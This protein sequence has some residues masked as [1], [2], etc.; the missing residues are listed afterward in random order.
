MAGE[1]TVATLVADVVK[2]SRKSKSGTLPVFGKLLFQGAV[3][4][5]LA[6]Y[7]AARLASLAA[8]SLDFLEF[9]KAGRPKVRITNPETLPDV[10]VIEIANDDMPFLVNSV[11]GALAEAGHEIQLMLHPVLNVARDTSGKL[12]TLEEKFSPTSAL[13]RESFMHIHVTRIDATAHGRLSEALERI[14]SD[15]RIAVLDW[16]AMQARLKE[17]LADYRTNPPPIPVDNLTE[18][19]AFLQWLLDNHFTFLGM[20][21]YAFEGGPE[22]GQL[23]AVPRSG[24]GILRNEATQVLRRGGELVS[25]TPAIRNF[26]LEPS[27]LIV[28]KSDVRATVHRRAAMEYIG[29]KLFDGDGE[30]KGELRMVGLYTSSAYTQNPSEIPLLRRKIAAV[31]V[32]SGFNPTG[33]SGKA[34]ISVLETLPRDELFQVDPETL[35]AMAHGILRLEE[36]PR[37]RLFVRRDRFD[38]FVSAFAYIP[39]DRFNSEVRQR[40]GEIVAK[41]FDGRVAS[42]EPYFGEGVL[43][44]VHF[45][46]LRNPGSDPNPDLQALESDVV[47]AVRTW[48]DRL[49]AEL[50][51]A[52]V[53]FAA[54]APR[55]RGAFPAGYRDNVTPAQSLKDIA[56]LAALAGDGSIAAEFLA[57]RTDK[58][59]ECHLRLYRYGEAIPLSNRLPILENMGLKAIEETTFDVLPQGATA[60][61]HDVLLKSADGKP[62]DIGSSAPALKA[63]FMAVWSGAAEN[64]Y[65]NALSLTTRMGWRDIALLRAEARYLRQITATFTVEYMAATL[66]KH[67]DIATRLVAA[68]HARFD[69]KR[70]DAVRYEALR[71]E[72]DEALAKVPSLDEDRIIRR[73]LNLVG[74]MQRTNYFQTGGDGVHPATTAFKVDATRIEGLPEPHPFAEIFVYSPDVEGV[75]LRF[76]RIARGGIRWS[77]RPEDFRTEVLGLAKAQNVKNAVIVPVGAKGGFVPKKLPQGGTREAVQAEAVRAY[78]LFI[79][80]LLDITDNL[81]DGKIM[82]PADVARHDGDDPYL[83]VAA[84]KG[85]ASFSDIAN[86]ISA[87]H[88]FW[89]DDAFASG[90]SAGYD[91]KKMAITARGAWEAVKRHF[92]EMDIDIQSTPFT[93]IGIGDMSGDVFGNGMLLSRHIRLRAAFDHRDIFIDPDPDPQSSY[94]ERDRLFQ[95]PRSSWQ[96]YDRAKISKGGGIFSRQAKSIP[97]T[98]ELTQLTGLKGESATP[99]QVVHALLIVEMDLLWFGGIG[100]FVKATSESHADVGDR[101]NDAVR[102]DATELRAKVVGEGANLALTQRARIEYALAGGRLNTDAID[103]SA[104][105]NSSDLEV[106]IKIALRSAEASGKL[107][108]AKRN[109][110]LTE[111]TD[112]VAGLVLRNNYLQTLS[113]TLSRGRGTEENG[114]VIQLMHDLEER[115]MLDR[116]LESLPGDAEVLARDARH[117]TLTRPELAV[118]LAHS[119]IAL[120][121]DLLKSSVPDD[122]YLGQELKRYFPGRMFGEF[123]PEIESHRLK[124]EIVATLL[125][126]S[127]I[128]RGGP[129]FVSRLSREA[130]A[131]PADIAAAFAVARDSFDFIALNQQVDG[132]DGRITS[133]LQTEIYLKLQLRLRRA[134][135]WFLRHA[136]LANGLDRVIAHFRAGIAALDKV[137][138]ETLPE[139]AAARVANTQGQLTDAGVSEELA[140]RLSRL[141]YLQRAP[142]IV[143]LAG[144]GS[145]DMRATARALYGAGVHLGID[146]ILAQ[147][148]TLIAGDFFERLAINRTI[149]QVLLSHRALVQRV[150]AQQG[151]SGDPWEAWSGS[152]A[153]KVAQAQ[154]TIG[155][156]FA[157]KTFDLAKLAVAQGVLSDLVLVRNP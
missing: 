123:K 86:G 48:D 47:E 129:A 96:D 3:E 153:A 37:T 54:L 114:F 106:N 34:L 75:H 127:M 121:D 63:T 120:Y 100:T 41:A 4:D 105:V 13:T 5:D 27:A 102:I 62:I 18:S 118:L 38:R 1:D 8:S 140:A 81:V 30:L 109:E 82:P 68:F 39:R 46:I 15:V 33:H 56:V 80:S 112:E 58:T 92:R 14:L 40:I 45:I 141:R 20:R 55:W 126:N 60:V 145:A 156:L 65:F 130:G 26:L 52:G 9:R 70:G 143:Q 6:R 125:S 137:L 21:E 12:V 85:T 2:A 147:A 79:S 64:D 108:R 93:V 139:P 87:G 24:L 69:P 94:A 49:Q 28:T 135:L 99:Q 132:L 111:M 97:L 78:T 133:A 136:D 103:N 144:D 66:V 22:D 73:Y 151:T 31:V 117:E 25:I 50:Q 67:S 71:V 104:G 19:I 10:S 155:K 101:A 146:R 59:D 17:A 115:Q 42:F 43:V 124:R 53:H 16:Q 89:L 76:G 74:A 23:K 29:V 154:G 32:A 157:E 142:D 83:V 113:L 134:T 152:H 116:R 77:D 11:L 122:A 128:N 138:M 119:K 57:S 148:G 91:H 98:P 35:A 84:D 72:I 107:T 61:I 110:L 150:M 90:G 7:D 131:T 36:R 51:A 95:L 149:D 44:R 88:R